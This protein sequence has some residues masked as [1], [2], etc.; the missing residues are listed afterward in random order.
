MKPTDAAQKDRAEIGGCA[1]S[2]VLATFNRAY[3]LGRAID[4]VLNQSFQNFELIVIDDGSTDDTKA[5]VESYED[6]RLRFFHNSANRGQTVCLNEG[7]RAARA[8]LIAFQDS[9]DEWLP[10]KLEKQVAAIN[11]A[12]ERVGVVYC[13]RWRV[14]GEEKTWSHAPHFTPEDGLVYVRALDGE[15][16][17]I[18]NQCLLIRRE[19]FENSG[20]FDE[21][22]R[23][24]VDMELIIRLSEKYLFLHLSDPL[25]NYYITDD[26]ISKRGEEVAINTWETIV[27][28]HHKG[29]RSL[30]AAFAKRAYWIGSFHMRASNGSKG[31][32]YLG[33]AFRAQ[34]MTLRYAM[35]Y[36][37]SCF[38]PGLYNYI[39]QRLH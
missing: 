6:P 7:I 28:K 39:H 16:H 20:Y 32:A 14:D 36:L 35:A 18:A 1:V 17:N 8:P 12:P 2:I 22:I 37:I 19:C 24:H 26:S 15:L 25:V 13:D 23:R 9:D 11:A 10:H 21:N 33:R 4:S 34:P 38:G 3:C 27:A 29:Y 5:L 31:R 30:P